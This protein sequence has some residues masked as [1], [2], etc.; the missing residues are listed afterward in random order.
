M[1]HREPPGSRDSNRDVCIERAI[2]PNMISLAAHSVIASTL[3]NNVGAHNKR[4]RYVPNDWFTLSWKRL[5]E[6][7]RPHDNINTW[8]V[9]WFKT[10]GLTRG[11]TRRRAIVAEYVEVLRFK[12]AA[13][14]L[15]VAESGNMK[16]QHNAFIR[17]T[18]HSTSLLISVGWR[19]RRST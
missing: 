18:H 16:D 1:F 11:L 13:P 9:A 4:S 19:L 17:M 8:T 15:H 6:S 14:R 12:M 3:R 7:R 2:E 10:A 5:L